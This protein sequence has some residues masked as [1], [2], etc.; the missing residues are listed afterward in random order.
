LL[1]NIGLAVAYAWFGKISQQHGWIALALAVSVALPVV[2]ASSA[3]TLSR[4]KPS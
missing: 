1:S 4:P 2:M 3:T